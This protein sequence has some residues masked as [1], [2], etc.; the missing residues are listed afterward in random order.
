VPDGVV[1][2]G[3][4]IKQSQLIVLKKKL[5]SL[6]V[7]LFALLRNLDALIVKFGDSLSELQAELVIELVTVFIH[8]FL[9]PAD[10]LIL[11][12]FE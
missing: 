3:S 11:L 1:H 2:C 7:L 12:L 8:G 6:L 10:H 9:D 4:H 5:G